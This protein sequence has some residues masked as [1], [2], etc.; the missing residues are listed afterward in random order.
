M[1]KLLIGALLVA[2]LSAGAGYAKGKSDIEAKYAEVHPL[3]T[4]VLEAQVQILQSRRL[5]EART[6]D[7]SLKLLT[8]AIS[9]IAVIP[10]AVPSLASTSLA[11]YYS[12]TSG[13]EKLIQQSLSE[14]NLR[15]QV[16][17]VQQNARII[18]L[19]ERI[20]AR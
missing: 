10:S 7:A 1:K 19:L 14:S 17:E 15:L 4:K 5:K 13:D 11:D 3:T 8:A 18:T 9:E 12:I 20:A 6:P 16:L 2:G